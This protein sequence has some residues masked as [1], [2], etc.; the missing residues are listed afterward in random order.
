MT[1]LGDEDGARAAFLRAVEASGSDQAYPQRLAA[2]LLASGW[3]TLALAVIER[4]EALGY[5]MGD[6]FE[7]SAELGPDE[8]SPA[9][10][11]ADAQI[12]LDE[13]DAGSAHDS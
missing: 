8:G 4:G 13:V 2:N 11:E 1:R 6:Q 9:P 5:P 10:A 3:V 7:I 12:D